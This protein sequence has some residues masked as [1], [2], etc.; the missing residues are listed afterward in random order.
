MLRVACLPFHFLAQSP[1]A[2]SGKRHARFA[3]ECGAK[4]IQATDEIKEIQPPQIVSR[5]SLVF[6]LTRREGER[7][8][9]PDW[10]G[11]ACLSSVALRR[12]DRDHFGKAELA[13]AT[14]SLG[15]S[16]IGGLQVSQTP[17]HEKGVDLSLLRDIQTK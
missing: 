3:V 2:V 9:C 8:R 16:E 6:C 14:G 5:T 13:F 12:M 4:G 7:P 15:V 1:V 11:H 17:D 10:E